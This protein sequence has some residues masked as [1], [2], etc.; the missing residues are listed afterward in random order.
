MFKTTSS[1]V[2][3]HSTRANSRGTRHELQKAWRRWQCD[4]HRGSERRPPWR[5]Q[6]GA[7]I[8]RGFSRPACRRCPG[9]VGEP[10]SI[11]HRSQRLQHCW[12]PFCVLQRAH[13]FDR[14]RSDGPQSLAA[15]RGLRRRVGEPG[16]RTQL[17]A[18]DGR[19]PDARDGRRHVRSDES[20][21]HLRRHRRSAR[22]RDGQGRCR[23]S[24]I[25]RWWP[26]MDS[27]GR[28]QLCAGI[29]E[30]ASGQPSQAER[31]RCGVDA[32]RVR[33]DG[34]SGFSAVTAAVRRS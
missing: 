13:Q 27:F 29:G 9:S 11:T 22:G 19:G 21:D 5:R 33:P 32:G 16:R 18:V 23:D 26:D 20:A 2:L 1:T 8:A 28:G 6:P 10:G 25:D 34:S 3:I 30:A 15:G 24:Q 7:G 12:Q 31:A 14:C 4:R 17:G